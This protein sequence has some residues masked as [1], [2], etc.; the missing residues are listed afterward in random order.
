[1]NNTRI[2]SIIMGLLL[3]TFLLSADL[4]TLEQAISIA[5]DK[6]NDIVIAMNSSEVA[7]N[8]ATIGNAGMLPNITVTNTYS[9]SIS[10]NNFT[11]STNATSSTNGAESSTT[12]SQVELNSIL[13]NGGKNYYTY[14]KLKSILENGEINNKITVENT[15]VSVIRAYYEIALYDENL[16]ISEFALNIS[17]SRYERIKN[18]VDY[19]NS[20]A[21]ELLNA[22]VDMDTDSISVLNAKLNVENAKRNLNY[23]LSRNIDIDFSV[24]SNVK[25]MFEND[26]D[27]WTKVTLENNSQLQASQLGA[28]Q[29]DLDIKVARA[30]FLPTLSGTASYGYSRSEAD[31]GPS[32]LNES[33]GFTTGLNLSFDLYSGQRNKINM[34][35]ASISK[36]SQYAELSQTRIA[37][38]KEVKNAYAIFNNA[39]F[40]VVIAE[41]SLDTAEINFARSNE[42]YN[43]GQ[44]TTTQFRDAQLNLIRAETRLINEKFTAK[45][46]EVELY[47]L[48]GQLQELVGSR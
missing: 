45:F 33:T 12:R 4:L 2:M 23:L 21:I 40:T 9:K 43:L 36:R 26:L 17:R 7:K 47:R 13:F 22:E 8:N 18:K 1:M 30:A 41:K 32:R 5:L 37:I 38:E 3:S 20:L 48:S 35:N 39:I 24:D 10:D 46:A 16:R 19:G 44:M 42:L 25:I 29:S 28:H 14:Q 34:E 27:Y 31:T 6:N 11:S 15:I